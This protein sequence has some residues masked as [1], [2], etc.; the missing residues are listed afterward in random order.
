MSKNIILLG[1]SNSVMVNGLS[2]G[3]KEGIEKLNA[4]TGGG[5]EFYNFALGGT[6]SIQRLYELIRNKVIIKNSELIICESNINDTVASALSEKESLPFNVLYRNVQ[7][8]YKELYALN[9][10][11][12]IIIFPTF[13]NRINNLHRLLCQKYNFNVIDMANYYEINNLK[14]FEPDHLH[15]LSSYMKKLGKSIIENISIFKL[16]KTNTFVNDNPTFEIITP[17]QTQMISYKNITKKT[18]ENSLF[19]EEIFIL[20]KDGTMLKFKDYFDFKIIAIHFWNNDI[21]GKDWYECSFRTSGVMI[22][23]GIEHIIKDCGCFNSVQEIQ[24]VNFKITKNTCVRYCDKNIPRKEFHHSAAV[25]DNR[26]NII[27]EI[28]IIAFFL[29]SPK[30]NYHTETI[31]F[32]ALENENIIISKDYDFSYLIPPIKFYKEIIDEFCCLMDNKKSASFLK[33]IANLNHNLAKIKIHNHLSYKLGCIMIRNSKSLLRYIK[34]PFILMIV[35]LAHKEQ[36]KANHFLKELKNDLDKEIILKEKECFTY[37]L[38]AA[39]IKASK[40]WH[41]GGYIRFL[42]MDLPRLK[43]EFKNKKVK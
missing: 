26:N 17:N 9:K 40:T 38:G 37:K 12:L 28:G 2:K 16:G 8:L 3:L 22:D 4:S 6:S 11:V 30:G 1:G 23:N 20:K 34:M 42:F 32:Q 19:K 21:S 33:Q 36:N 10:K 39:L 15:P 7:W 41:K 24:N 29:A 14:D 31:D 27:D 5:L 43:K 18:F 13:N 35:V 25:W